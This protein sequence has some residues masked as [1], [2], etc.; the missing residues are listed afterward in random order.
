MTAIKIR[1]GSVYTYRTNGWD[2]ISQLTDL[3][4]GDSVRVGHCPGFKRSGCVHCGHTWVYD[5]YTGEFIGMVDCAS[6]RR[7]P[8]GVAEVV[9]SKEIVQYPPR[10]FVPIHYKENRKRGYILSDGMVHKLTFDENGS[11]ATGWFE[12]R[13]EAYNALRL[14]NTTRRRIVSTQEE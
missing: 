10:H 8:Q 14:W 12:T 13:Q 5:V 6:L 4:D 1:C 9:R 3:K 7:E 2:R 11:E